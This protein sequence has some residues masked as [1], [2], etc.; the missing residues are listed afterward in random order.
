VSNVNLI[1]EYYTAFRSKDYARFTALS[2]PDLTWIQS[3]GFPG[4]ATWHGPEA[5]IA[6]VFRGNAERWA[7]FGFEIAEFLDAQTS[8]VVVGTYRGTHR[9][10]ERSFA[11][12]TVHIFDVSDGKVFR[13]RQFTDTKVICDA[14]PSPTELSATEG[15]PP[16]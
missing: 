13:F 7:N 1:K 12:A 16:A 5:V 15:P 10:S 9:I 14:L 2:S 3:D 4:G 8:V 6:G 11:A